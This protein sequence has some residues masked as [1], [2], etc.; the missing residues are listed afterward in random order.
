VVDPNQD[1]REFEIGLMF[2]IN[3]KISEK[4]YF[5]FRISNSITPIYEANPI[6]LPSWLAGGWHRGAGL[7]L[8][9]YFNNPNFK[10]EGLPPVLTE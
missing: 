9:Y 1:L 6:V 8:T 2:G 5:K 3:Y 10:S 4:V 7:N